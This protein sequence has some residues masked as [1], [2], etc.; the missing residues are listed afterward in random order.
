MNYTGHWVYDFAKGIYLMV[1]YHISKIL[2]TFEVVGLIDS[3]RKNTGSSETCSE[4]SQTS[5]MNLFAEI[6]NG[7]QP[8][9]ILANNAILDVLLGSEYASDNTT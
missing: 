2:G 6:F 7:I 9:T 8:L 1:T 4:P 5:K 3:N